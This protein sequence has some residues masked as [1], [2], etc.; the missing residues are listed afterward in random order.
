MIFKRFSLLIWAWLV[1]GGGGEGPEGGTGK[2]QYVYIFHPF[3]YNSSFHKLP[4]FLSV[5]ALPDVPLRPWTSDLNSLVGKYQY[6]N[7]SLFANA[8]F[9]ASAFRQMV[10]V[11]PIILLFTSCHIFPS[12]VSYFRHKYYFKKKEFSAHYNYN[13]SCGFC[14]H[15]PSKSVHGSLQNVLQFLLISSF[16]Q[17]SG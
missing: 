2:S 7:V 16:H 3:K 10:M 11:T 15:L 5:S 9:A 13:L 1:A 12:S 17:Q 6:I 4:C 8:S 14:L